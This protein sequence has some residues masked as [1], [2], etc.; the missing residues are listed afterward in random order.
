M[1][2]EETQFL[3]EPVPP[4]LSVSTAALNAP[5]F[6]CYTPSVHGPLSES[7]ASLAEVAAPLFRTA[8]PYTVAVARHRII[9]TIGHTRPCITTVESVRL[10]SAVTNAGASRLTREP[11]RT[12]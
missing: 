7:A 1:V 6:E 3:D 5:P 8:R 9:T 10:L 11:L 2:L 12:P 4:Q